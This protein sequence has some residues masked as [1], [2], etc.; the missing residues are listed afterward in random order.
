MM[1]TRHKE[2]IQMYILKSPPSTYYY[3]IISYTIYT[4]K[5]RANILKELR[6]KDFKTFSRS[7][8]ND[9]YKSLQKS[10]LRAT[11]LD[12]LSRMSLCFRTRT[13]VLGGDGG[14]GGGGGGDGG[15]NHRRILNWMHNSELKLVKS[16]REES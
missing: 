14:S 12:H 3:P 9:K 15:G 11:L 10:W 8:I 16:S 13:V 1:G 7:F 2:Y 6:R 5:Y 4:R